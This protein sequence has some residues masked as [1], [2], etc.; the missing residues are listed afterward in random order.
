MVYGQG[1]CKTQGTVFTDMLILAITTI[2]I[3]MQALLSLPSGL[4]QVWWRLA[5]HATA[6]AYPSA[7]SMP[8]VKPTHKGHEGLDSIAPFLRFINS[9]SVALEAATH[10]TMYTNRQGV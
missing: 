4:D 9:G 2:S 6:F 1:S 3:F 10:T 5:F 8:R 7:D